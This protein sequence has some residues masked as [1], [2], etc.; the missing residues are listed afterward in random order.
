MYEDFSKNICANFKERSSVYPYY[1][2]SLHE[3]KIKLPAEVGFINYNHF[4]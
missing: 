4:Q 1:F 2:D 3:T